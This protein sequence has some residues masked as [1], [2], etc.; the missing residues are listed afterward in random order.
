MFNKL[1]AR[2]SRKRMLAVID[3]SSLSF[4]IA[5]IFGAFL[6]LGFLL[7]VYDYIAELVPFLKKIKFW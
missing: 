3:L 7:L 5:G 4:A 2:L 6:G 1:K